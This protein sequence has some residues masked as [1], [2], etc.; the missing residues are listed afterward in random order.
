MQI[1][2]QFP[3]LAKCPLLSQRERA[4]VRAITMFAAGVEELD[5]LALRLIKR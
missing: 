5:G 1:N 4:R 3:R 2:G